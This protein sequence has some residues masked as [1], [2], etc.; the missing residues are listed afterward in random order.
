MQRHIAFALLFALAAAS[1]QAGD[2]NSKLKIGDPAPAWKNLPGVDGKQHSLADL[3]VARLVLVVFTCNS[4]DVATSYE[5]RIIAFAKKYKAD[6]PVV[7]INVS[8]KPADA[9]T[10]MQERAKEKKFPYPYL[11][12]QSQEIGKAFGANYTPEFFLLDAD[13]KIAYMGA[14]DDNGDADQVKKNYVER[15]VAA[16]LQNGT[17]T[18]TETAPRGCR[19]RYPRAPR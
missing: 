4:C 18:T 10:F 14:L 3:K 12:D 16:M 17:P 13:R 1:S 11:F 15:A 8:T 19:I 9:L 6:V 7:A 5:D 2:F